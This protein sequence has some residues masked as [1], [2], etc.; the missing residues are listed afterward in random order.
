MLEK[1]FLQ[2]LNMSFTASFVVAFVLIARLLLKK[3]PKIFSYILWSVVLFRLICPFSFES[4][5][6][7]LPTKATPISQDIIYMQIPQIDTGITI[8]NNAVNT[9]LP[10]A[11]P[12]SSVNPL[13]IWVF[14]GSLLWLL[15]I[16]VLLIYSLVTLFRLQKQLQDATLYRDN[17]FISQKIDTAFVLGVFRPKIYLPA[18]LSPTERDYIL[19]H[20]KTHIKRLDHIVKIIS[21]FAFCIHWFNPFIWIAFFFSEKDMEMSCDEAVIKQLGNDVKK[22]YSS[23]LLTLAT[24]KRIIGGTPLAFGEGNTKGRIKNVLNYKN[25]AFW[26]GVVALVS[27]ICVIVGLIANPKVNSILLPAKEEVTSIQIE[28]MNEGSSLGIIKTSSISDIEVILNALKDS[29]KTLRQTVNDAPYKKDYFRIDITGTVSRTL[30]LYKDGLQ[31]YIEDL[32]SGI[33]RTNRGT[34]TTIAKV[35]TANGGVYAEYNATA[36][37]NARTQYTG[38]NSAVGKLIGLLSVPEGLHYDHFE[39]Q[40]EAQTYKIEIVYSVPTDELAGYDTKNSSVANPFRKNALLLLALIENV[41]EIQ[42]TLT[43]GNQKV[44]F[45]NGREWAD[46]TVAGDVRD[47]ADSPEKLQELIDLPIATSIADQLEQSIHNAI[48]QQN[49]ND[50]HSVD[51][52]AESHVVLATEG[53]GP[54]GNGSEIDT[55]TVYAIVLKQGFNLDKNGF[56]E[57]G[58]SHIPSAITFD[59]SD[60][61]EYTLKEYWI[62]RDGSYYALDIESKFPKPIAHD[63]LDTQKY[64]LSQVQCCY[65]QAIEYGNV[66]T[67]AMISKLID[68]ITSM[69]DS[70]SNWRLTAAK[71]DLTY[72]GDYMLTYAYTRFLEGNQ[73]NEKAKIMEEA[74]RVILNQTNENID[75]AGVS[76]QEWFDAYLANLKTYEVKEG[77]DFIRENMPK[78]YLLLTIS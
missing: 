30:F 62:P 60:E 76:G 41:D 9:I 24:G 66:D 59:V 39:L 38:D 56:L 54:A 11:T 16:A 23:S 65:S 19:L 46:Y 55:L 43:D 15:G 53:G 13:Q 29:N 47:Y 63:A 45:I 73:T 10:A 8:L 37:W 57:E 50:Y 5:L 67:E 22:D 58:G 64:I 71:R 7:L 42:A 40:T 52:I 48:L 44:G 72:F 20:E 18:N 4:V 25:P 12:Q 75:F 78:G 32:Y 14:I 61:G 70:Q 6:S 21:F 35:Y 34:S 69:T 26:V 28:Q 17:I 31:Y 36:L 51:F 68:D 74:C 1:L 49:K 77:L 33:Y 2:I 3:A 27:V